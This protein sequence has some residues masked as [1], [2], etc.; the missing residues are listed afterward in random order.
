MSQNYQ[1]QIAPARTFCL[2]S[3][4]SGLAKQGL[5]RGGN[6]GNAVVIVDK[7][8]DDEEVKRFKEDFG[9]KFFKGDRGLHK[10]QILRF[11]N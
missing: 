11:R 2:L 5:I 7:D 8:I 1:K 6:L 10:T 4:V 9:I 3:E